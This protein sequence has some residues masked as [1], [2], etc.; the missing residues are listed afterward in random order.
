MTTAQRRIHA[1]T[2]MLRTALVAF[3]ALI[4]IALI[5]HSL[6]QYNPTELADAV[7]RFPL[8]RAFAALGFAAGSYLSLTFFDYLGLRYAGCSLSW[9][10]AALASFTSLSLGHNIGFSALSAGVLRYRFYSRWGAS[11]DKVVK[12]IFI[13]AT[14][15]VVGLVT[16]AGFAVLVE[17]AAVQLLGGAP[18]PV[19][20]IVFFLVPAGYVGAC[21]LLRVSYVYKG[22]TLQMPSPQIACLQVV[23]GTLN[24]IC[25]AACL[26]Q[27]LLAAH[28]IGFTKVAAAYVAGN[29]ATIVSHVPGGLGVLE[30]VIQFVLGKQNVIVP[31]LMFRLIYF[32][33]PL[34]LGS[35]ALIGSEAYFKRHAARP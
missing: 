25:V 20:A 33:I 8:A 12:V 9:R 15:V 31:L 21:L 14:S 13:S 22:I 11:A 16:L 6:S 1:S 35:A 19:V 34:V 27:C 7:E 10:R 23:V 3:A 32:I 5:A 24:F 2:Q 17:P 29:I 28:D 30:T 4:G 18:R 26:Q